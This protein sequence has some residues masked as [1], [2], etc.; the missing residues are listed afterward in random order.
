MK[1]NGNKYIFEQESIFFLF[2]EGLLVTFE[3]IYVD[4][5]AIRH[6]KHT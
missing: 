5:G 3:V 1:E 4:V 6:F 2:S